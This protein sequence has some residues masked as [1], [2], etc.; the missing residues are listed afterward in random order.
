[1]ACYLE[2]RAVRKLICN[3]NSWMLVLLVWANLASAQV[4]MP[5][6]ELSLGM[7]RIEAE[8]AMNPEHRAMGLMNRREMAQNQGMLFVFTSEQRHCMWMRNTYLPLSVAFL[9]R[10]G[11]IINIADM[12]PQSDKSHCASADARFALE[13]NQGW[14]KRRGFEKGARVNGVERAPAPY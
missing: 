9:D 4:A 13:M 6:M 10:E 5:R 2:R 11:K 1:M 12:T 3:R 7:H 8:V 14:F